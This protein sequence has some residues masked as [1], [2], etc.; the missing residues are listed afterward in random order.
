MLLP[1]ALTLG[2]YLLGAM[3]VGTMILLSHATMIPLMA[4]A[5]ILRFRE[6]AHP[7]HDDCN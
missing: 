6:Y 2:P 4:V 3:T 7:S 5:V 1:V